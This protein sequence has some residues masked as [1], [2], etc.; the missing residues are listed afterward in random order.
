MKKVVHEEGEEGQEMKREGG[1]EEGRG[2][3]A[4]EIK[5]EVV[6]G[7]E[8]GEEKDKDKPVVQV[9]FQCEV[10]V[11]FSLPSLPSSPPPSSLLLLLSLTI[12]I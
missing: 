8:G 7:E 2:V 4:L 10:E 3:A 1:G 12:N 11:R 6:K 9:E 5:S